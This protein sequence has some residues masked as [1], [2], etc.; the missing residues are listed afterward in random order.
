MHS[1]YAQFNSYQRI[2]SF[3]KRYLTQN[4]RGEK[5]RRETSDFGKMQKEVRLTDLMKNEYQFYDYESPCF[6]KTFNE[7][8]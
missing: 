3:Y 2:Q 1:S 5:R 7:W 8:L 4:P 6:K